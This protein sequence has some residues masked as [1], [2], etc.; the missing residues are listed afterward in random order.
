M[1]EYFSDVE[2]LCDGVDFNCKDDIYLMF[3][4]GLWN[5]VVYP[6]AVQ[7]W[8]Q[9]TFDILENF[10]ANPDWWTSKR[11]RW[12]IF[13]HGDTILESVFVDHNEDDGA[14]FENLE[15]T[16]PLGGNM[17]GY[18]LKLNL[19]M[20]YP[21][22]KDWAPTGDHVTNIQYTRSGSFEIDFFKGQILE[23]QWAALYFC[24]AKIGKSTSLPQL[25]ANGG[26]LIL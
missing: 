11:G 15:W 22:G 19:N 16:A 10:G 25:Y 12:A 2:N 14:V 18:T 9:E 1:I 21:G 6:T 17:E 5:P 23:L 4:I 3:T 24:M 7:Q 26:C 13:K 20:I 8:E